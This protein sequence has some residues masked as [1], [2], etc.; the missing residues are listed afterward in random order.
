MNRDLAHLQPYPFEKLAKLKAAVTPPTDMS[1][2]AF[3]IGEPKH[4][5]PDF[6]VK[7]LADNL[8]GLSVYPTTKGSL[9]LRTSIANWCTRRFHLSEGVLSPED[10]VLPVTGTREAIFAFTQAAVDRVPGALVVSPNPFYQIYEGAAYLAGATPHYLNCLA[11]NN[12]IPDYDAVADDVWD[13]CQILFICSPGN[14]TGAVTQF[15]TLKKLIALADKHDFIIAS[16]ECYSEIYFDEANPPIGLLEAC[17]KLGRHDFD[18]C[19]VMHSLSKRSNLP[20]MRSGFI[21]G[22]A[23][24]LEPFLK[25]R[26]YHGC[27]MQAQHQIASIAAWDDEAHVLDNRNKYREK[28]REVVNIL[29]PV[30]EVKQPDASFYLWA[31]TPIADDE[32]AQRLFAEQHMT[33]LPGSYVSREVDGI[34]P[35][36]GYVR[37]ALV[38]TLDECIEGAK[39]I[40]TFVE[41]LT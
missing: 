1:H 34:V 14:P 15:D 19:V 5:S 8:N 10:N 41:S 21:A 3:S 31:K 7:A 28:F 40:R 13:N 18:K 30:M 22:D 9:E 25:Y 16:D 35:G 27:A 20:G 17:E 26:T 11:D 23:K 24:L 6:V 38:A 12:F 4:A 33:V 32:F 39:R 2:I 29:S 37:M 36:A